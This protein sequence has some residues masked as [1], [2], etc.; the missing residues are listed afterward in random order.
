MLI[1]ERK[2]NALPL[3]LPNAATTITHPPPVA[4]SMMPPPPRP[5][6]SA[7]GQSR[8]NRQIST[9]TLSEDPDADGDAEGETA[10]A[11]GDEAADDTLYCFCQQKS[12]GEMIGCDNEECEYEW[13]SSAGSRVM[14]GRR[15]LIPVP[16]QMRQ[17]ADEPGR[18]VVLPRVCAEVGSELE[19][20]YA[21]GTE[22]VD[23][24]E[25]IGDE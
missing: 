11:E 24:E 12:Y 8:H 6:L 19:R 17:L 18:Y 5:S 3:P 21:R 25:E 20:W 22:E 1:P 9:S 4:L 16:P 10:E 2:P 13:V 7:R 23:G 14:V 15:S